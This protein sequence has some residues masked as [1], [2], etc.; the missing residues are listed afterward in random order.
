MTN[1]PPLWVDEVV[2]F[3]L[4]ACTAM[5]LKLVDDFNEPGVREGAGLYTFAIAAGLRDSAARAMLGPML[6]GRA[7]RPT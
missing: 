7:P 5:G 3:F 4:S 2:P 1:S 6:S